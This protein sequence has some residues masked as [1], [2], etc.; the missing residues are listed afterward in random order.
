MKSKSRKA[1]SKIKLV[2][3][4]NTQVKNILKMKK[5]FNMTASINKST[6]KGLSKSKKKK[7][8]ELNQRKKRIDLRKKIWRIKIKNLKR[9]GKVNQKKH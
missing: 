5:K 7:V 1:K 4:D 3:S 6:F 2:K 8:N 9:K